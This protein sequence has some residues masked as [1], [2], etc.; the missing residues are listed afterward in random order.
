MAFKS[1]EDRLKH[2][3]ACMR[4]ISD[5]TK[6]ST[7]TSKKQNSV[8]NNARTILDIFL[9]R[10]QHLVDY[11]PSRVAAFNPKVQLIRYHPD[12]REYNIFIQM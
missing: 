9:Q 6:F 5:L 11:I 1:N 2:H 7:E 12:V 8:M 10:F 3:R 4:F